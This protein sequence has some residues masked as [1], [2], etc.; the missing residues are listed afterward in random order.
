M[1]H[2]QLPWKF[3]SQ[4]L[5]AELQQLQQQPWIAHFVQQNYTGEWDILPLRGPA[6]AQHPVRMAY[7]DPACKAFADTP[8][9]QPNSYLREVLDTFYCPLLSVRLM[10]LSP[11]SQI[12]EHRDHDLCVEQGFAR[13]HIPI[14]TNPDVVFLLNGK[15]VLMQEGECWYLR[16]QDLHA[17]SNHGTT[18][19]VHLV[20]DAKV[21]DWLAEQLSLC[22]LS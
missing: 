9:L 2:C 20:I 10:R 18:D 11:G 21:N 3:D 19:R 12:K 5:Q 4:R 13:L 15:R 6:D 8:F 22:A 17:V 14:T 7:S 16:L 1:D